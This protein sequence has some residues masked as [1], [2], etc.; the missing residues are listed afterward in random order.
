MLFPVLILDEY[1]A[2][3][4]I[5]ASL[6]DNLAYIRVTV[7]IA[8]GEEDEGGFFAVAP[9]LGVASQGESIDEALANVEEAIDEFIAGLDELGEL[10]SFL[11][12]RDVLVHPV[13][14]ET[15]YPVE[16]SSGEVVTVLVVALDKTVASL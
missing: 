2:R 3:A 11:H 6:M 4:R 8:P 16:V 7:R 1:C 10:Q 5:R 14:P 15:S 13:P 9:D 12:Q